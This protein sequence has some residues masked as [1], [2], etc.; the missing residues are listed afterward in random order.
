[1]RWKML[2]SKGVSSRAMRRSTSSEENFPT[3]AEQDVHAFADLDAR[4]F[5]QPGHRREM[6][7][8]ACRNRHR[9]DRRAI[10]T[11]GIA[12]PGAA[13]CLARGLRIGCCR[14]YTYVEFRSRDL[15]RGSFRCRMEV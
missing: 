8:G 7:I 2:S 14:T 15:A 10:A 9:K 13:F 5:I 3:E 6:A 11:T 12:G 4:I 1:M